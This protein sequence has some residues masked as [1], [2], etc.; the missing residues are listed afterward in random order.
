M[1]VYNVTSLIR[2]LIINRA[3]IHVYQ[4]RIVGVDSESFAVSVRCKPYLICDGYAISCDWVLSE[5]GGL[6]GIGGVEPQ[7][8]AEIQELC[9]LLVSATRN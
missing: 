2:H 1:H 5:I 6:I 4:S 7:Q 3:G 9:E 8:L